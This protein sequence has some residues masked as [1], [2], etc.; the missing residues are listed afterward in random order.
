MLSIS[1]SSKAAISVALFC[2]SFPSFSKNA[3]LCWASFRAL[4][5]A[6]FTARSVSLFC[7]SSSFLAAFSAVSCLLP[8]Y[9]LRYLFVVLQIMQIGFYQLLLGFQLNLFE[10]VVCFLVAPLSFLLL[11]RLGLEQLRYILS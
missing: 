11:L 9:Q 5:C 7:L 3:V 10:I 6:A 2:S 8:L 4:S 1:F